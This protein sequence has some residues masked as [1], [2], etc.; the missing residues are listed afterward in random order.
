MNPF[1]DFDETWKTDRCHKQSKNLLGM[2]LSLLVAYKV[3][4]VNYE[5][6][7]N[8]TSKASVSNL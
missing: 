8:C 2:Q 4:H 6:R 5:S 7:P 1:T 3:N